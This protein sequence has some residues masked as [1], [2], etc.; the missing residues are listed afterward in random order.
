MTQQRQL[1]IQ[2]EKEYRKAHPQPDDNSDISNAAIGAAVM[3]AFGIF[4]VY[5]DFSESLNAQSA[6]YF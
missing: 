2:K 4:R 1:E 3:G 5:A 6:L